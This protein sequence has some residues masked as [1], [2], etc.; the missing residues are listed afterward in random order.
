MRKSLLLALLALLVMSSCKEKVVYKSFNEYPVY[1]GDDIGLTYSAQNSTFRMWA[2]TAEKVKL[3]LYDDGYEGGAYQTHDMTA[4]EDGTWTLK[5]DENLKGKFYTFQIKIGEKWMEETPG[6]L[7]KA[8]GLNGKRAA[9]VDMDESNPAGWENDARPHQDDLGSMIIYETHLQDF[10]VA[11]NSGMRHKGKYLALTEHGTHTPSGSVTGL[12]YLKELGVTH[13]QLMPLADFKSVDESR[14]KESH[15]SWGYDVLNVNVPEGSYATNA[16]NPL[17]RIREFKEMVMALHKAGIRVNMEVVYSHTAVGKG[18]NLDLLAPGYFYRQ[19]ADS[20]WADGFGQGNELAT[21]RGMVRQMIVQSLKYW[22]AEMHVDGFSFSGMNGIDIETMNAVRAELDK[23]DPTIAVYGNDV[24]VTKSPLSA[25]LRAGVDNGMQLNNVGV[26][27]YRY[28]DV[29]LGT[30]KSENIAGFVAATDSLEESVRFG[31]TGGVGHDSI[32]YSSVLYASKPQVKSPVQ[33]IN[34]VSTHDGLTLID[35]LRQTPGF[36]G[37]DDAQKRAVKLAQ[38]ILFTSQGIPLLYGG[39][40][41]L[42]S[43][44]GLANTS[45]M[46]DSVNR[47][48]WSGKMQHEEMWNYC[49]DLI[50]LRKAHKAFRVTDRDL[51]RKQLQFLNFDRPNVVGFLLK[52]HANGDE[53]KDILVLYNG[54][55]WP[56]SVQIPEG[57]W[58]VVCHDGQINMNG[59]SQSA[60]GWFTLAGTAATI[61]YQ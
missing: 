34:F 3:L 2:P 18:S 35:K 17:V 38:T 41:M 55:R 31:V 60:G 53:W 36:S 15:Y 25:S 5:L 37:A 11:A 43:K 16:K 47:I 52:D 12:D 27:S 10:S 59:L 29:L 23:I 39:E 57:N 58:T 42:R 14:P 6:M 49:K 20:S 21:E 54:G 40:E 44:R 45:Q 28:K 48:D 50:A 61:M 33:A 9:I 8:T 46:S 22:A 51:L 24:N 19:N 1:A 4:S 7:V 56:V 26:Y 13:I 30:G 32:D